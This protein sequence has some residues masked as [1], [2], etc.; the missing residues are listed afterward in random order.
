[1]IKLV[2]K[3]TVDFSAM[4]EEQAEKAENAFK[5]VVIQMRNLAVQNCP[6]DTGALRASVAS[7]PIETGMPGA[8]QLGSN[9]EYA[10][11]VHDGTS[12]MPARPFIAYAVDQLEDQID[13]AIADAIR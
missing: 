8:Y 1:M 9:M 6:S 10:G 7:F 11:Y 3:Q 4:S 5:A 12:K 13:Q 2:G